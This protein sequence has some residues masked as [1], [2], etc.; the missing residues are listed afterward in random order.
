MQ[1]PA[2]AGLLPIVASNLGT[3]S[4][5]IVSMI[6]ADLV[7]PRPQFAA[8]DPDISPPSRTPTYLLVSVFRI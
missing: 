8:F 5:V 4:T 6:A 7:A 1:A 3:P 2:S